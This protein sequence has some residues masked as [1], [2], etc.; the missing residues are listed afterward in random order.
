MRQPVKVGKITQEDR[1]VLM[2]QGR[3]A[4]VALGYMNQVI[5]RLEETVISR[6]VAKHGSGTIS[7]A[8]L[9]GGIG[10]IAGYRNVLVALRID[11]QRANKAQE[12]EMNNGR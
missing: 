10:E 9:R 7:E 4:N 12:E 11:V 3:H 1:H 8:D 5:G 6:L 2:E